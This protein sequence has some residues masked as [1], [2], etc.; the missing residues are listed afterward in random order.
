MEV[1]GDVILLAALSQPSHQQT[2]VYGMVEEEDV[3]KMAA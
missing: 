1:V 2:S 3:A